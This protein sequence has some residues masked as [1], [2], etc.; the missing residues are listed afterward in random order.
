MSIFVGEDLGNGMIGIYTPFTLRGN[1][2]IM[3]YSA[4]PMFALTELLIRLKEIG[5]EKVHLGGSENA[6]L[7]RTKELLGAKE[8]KTYWVFKQLS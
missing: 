2:M 6:S 3:G 8:D 5:F 7:D 1:P 4:M